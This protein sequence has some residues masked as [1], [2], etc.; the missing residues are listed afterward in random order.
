MKKIK[1]LSAAII[2]AGRI[3]GGYDE[4]RVK[5][6]KGVYTHAGAFRAVQDIELCT[7]F[8]TEPRRGAAFARHWGRGLKVA[9]TLKEIIRGHHDIISVCT[10]D[11][12]HYRIVKELILHKSCKTIF[13]EKP[14]ATAARQI[15][16]LAELAERYGINVVVNFQRHFDLEH[17]KLARLLRQAPRKVLSVQGLYIKGL[18]HIGV[19]MLDTLRFLFGNPQAVIAT[20]RV[21]NS[22]IR[23]YSYDFTLYYPDFTVGVKTAD[24]DSWIYNYHVFE[25]DVLLKDR[26]IRIV[27]N[28]RTILQSSIGSYGY[29]GV[30]V[31]N[32]ITP[33]VRPT[34]Y[35]AA[36]VNSTRYIYEITTGKRRHLENTLRSS[37]SNMLLS[38]AVQKSYS[39]GLKKITFKENIW[40]K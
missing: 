18:A 37:Q 15:S 1:K 6:E 24:S 35:P 16:E 27:D 39:S 12:T 20:R 4:Q 36:M 2:G 5:G 32:D 9:G 40:K 26:R 31:L 30:K 28:S 34:G 13:V 21:Y 22:E 25:L 33:E 29:S 7:V 38:E 17:V 11:S 10:P 3:A 14:A 19:T 8:D 23:G